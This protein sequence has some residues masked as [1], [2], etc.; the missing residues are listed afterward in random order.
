MPQESVRPGGKLLLRPTLQALG[1]DFQTTLTVGA[2]KDITRLV[3]L[4]RMPAPVEIDTAAAKLGQG[5]HSLEL[6]VSGND[7]FSDNN[8]RFATIV[9]QKPRKG[10]VISANP[11][12]PSEELMRALKS[13]DGGVYSAQ[14]FNAT[15]ADVEGGVP[16]EYDAVFL[17]GVPAPSEKLWQS[18][19]DFARKR[20][21]IAIIPGRDDEMDVRAYQSP[22]A[23]AVLPGTFE[24]RLGKPG[25]ESA[26]MHWDWKASKSLP[27]AGIFRNP[28]LQSSENWLREE[29]TYSRVFAYW[30][31]KP[32]ASGA[33]L[34][35]YQDKAHS[36][37]L[38]ERKI[39]AGKVLQFTTSFDLRDPQRHPRWNNYNEEINPF[40][41]IITGLTV[42]H[43]LGELD[44][45]HVNFVLGREEASLPVRDL[46]G[47]GNLT[48]H[49]LAS[50]PIVID[51]KLARVSIP[52]AN[53]PGNYQI[54]Q[55]STKATLAAFSMNLPPE[56]V[57]LTPWPTAEIEN[58]FGAG[59]RVPSDRQANLRQ[60]LQGRFSEPVELF[61]IFMVALLVLLAL[62]NLLA[63]RFYRREQ[64]TA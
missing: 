45:M 11:L 60:L 17:Y 22:A 59:V 1:Q 13:N 49:G 34:I 31:T 55:N 8:R 29:D 53:L 16:R 61:P 14:F 43:M 62:E 25:D 47:R 51:E 52:E 7:A 63:N 41:V 36:P 12:P 3:K 23:K 15:P 18:L 9:V 48:L 20:G 28:I 44:S 27:G 58:I 39:G 32:V 50:G 4:G 5:F 37:A 38:L 56:E 54:I 26:G 40:F 19:E 33:V 6:T 10:L 2:V 64:E 24:K 42:R 46:A 21:S 30:E 35:P 57:D